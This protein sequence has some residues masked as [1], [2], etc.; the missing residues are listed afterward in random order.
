MLKNNLFLGILLL[1][2]VALTACGGNEAAEVNVSGA[3]GELTSNGVIKIAI[4]G[5]YPPYNF[6]NANNEMDGFD[7]DI[8]LELANRM[9]VKAEILAT[10]W[11]SMIPGLIA[12]KYDIIVSDMAITEERKKKVDF[13]DPYF[14]TGNQLFVPTNSSI[15]GPAEMKGKKIGVT[16][17]TT[18]ADMATQMGADVVFYKNDFLAFTDMSSNRLDGVVTDSGVGSQII[19]EKNY[20]AE[21]IGGLLNREDAGITINKNK[22]AL[23]KE[24]NKNLT[25]MKNDGTYEKIS[26]NWFNKDIR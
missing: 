8:S 17:S 13:S 4:E 20:P 5:A 22:K 7:V 11:D 25:N 19:K 12:N 14:T 10:P 16:I 26:F 3:V 2:M 15:K 6:I 1:V 23:L 24:I 21:S 9:G 18:A